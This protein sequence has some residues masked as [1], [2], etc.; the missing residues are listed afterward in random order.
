MEMISD[1]E[2][3][4]FEVTPWSARPYGWIYY[5]IYSC[6]RIDYLNAYFILWFFQ[7]LNFSNDY[8]IVIS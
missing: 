4:G 1:V 5:V 7:N 2:H 6:I 8:N 3:H